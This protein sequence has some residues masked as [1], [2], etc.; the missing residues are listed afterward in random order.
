M[1]KIILILSFS[2]LFSILGLFSAEPADNQIKGAIVDIEKYEKQFGTQTS[3]N[4]S[5]IRRS[6]KLLTLTRQRLDGSPNK[7]HESW[8]EADKRYIALVAHMNKLANG[9]ATASASAST[10]SRPSA[11]ARQT[12]SNTSA[13]Q[14]TQPMISQYR[15]RIKKIQRDI[16]SVWDTMDK[17]GVKPFQDPEYVKKFEASALRIQESIAKYD[18]WKSDPDVVLAT[19]KLTELLNMIKFGK[20]HAAKELAELG[21]VQ[22]RL[23]QIN[24][25]IRQL[26]VPPTPE[27]PYKQGELTTWVTQLARAQQAATKI[28]KPLPVI[29]ERA[30]LPNNSMTVEQGGLY[31]LNDVDRLER[32]LIDIAKTINSNLEVF[33]RNLTAQLGQIEAGLAYYSEHDPAD[34]NDQTNHFLGEGRADEVRAQLA[35][36][37]IITEEAANYSQ[38]LN[39]NNHSARLG[40][41]KKLEHA[42]NTYEANYQKAREL[43]R[44]PKAATKDSKLTKIARETLAGY[45]DVGN[46][47]RMVINTEKQHRTKETSDI[48]FDDADISL[49]GEI[50]LSGTQTTYFYEWDQ[51]Q[52][53]TAEPKG[54]KY[55]IY[56]NTLKYFTSGS[57]TTPLNQWIMSGRLQGSEIPKENIKKD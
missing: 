47:E 24:Q 32:S 2:L 41:L 12:V 52:V 17:G 6:L 50:T 20:D 35:R 16:A 1:K 40:L 55:F 21:D 23:K 34:R 22:A 18:P 45:E 25:Q 3:T 15:V 5:S 38:L 51:F 46:I 57:T 43:V 42:A 27:H 29:K 28:H 48:E 4:P 26:N 9:G 56:Y 13:Q 19:Q 10:A 33:G 7:S 8:I 14:S 30:Y 11:P 49:S 37:M 53:A 31:D 54:D 39:D 44:M 36:D